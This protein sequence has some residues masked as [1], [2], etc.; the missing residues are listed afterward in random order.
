MLD[1]VF[2]VIFHEFYF[3]MGYGFFAY[4]VLFCNVVLMFL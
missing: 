3:K 2:A 1:N 4:L